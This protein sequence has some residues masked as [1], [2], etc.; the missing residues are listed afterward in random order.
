MQLQINNYLYHGAHEVQVDETHQ[1]GPVIRFSDGTKIKTRYEDTRFVELGSN[2]LIR[3]KSL[4][5]PICSMIKT[6]KELLH[7]KEDYS[8]NIGGKIF[9]LN[10]YLYN[11]KSIW[12]FSNIVTL[13]YLHQL[14]NLVGILNPE[15]ELLLG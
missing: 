1:D 5:K 14:Q 10:G 11:D 6:T 3:L 8:V 2:V 9:F 7:T 13:H 4:G 15:V 12:Q